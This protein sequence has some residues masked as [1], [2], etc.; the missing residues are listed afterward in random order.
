MWFWVSTIDGI[1]QQFWEDE[2]LYIPGLTR[3]G[4][5]AYSP[6]A[7]HRETIGLS[8]ALEV[9]GAKFFGNGASI[10]GYLKHPGN[11]S[12]EAA[13]RLK[14][15]FE[16]KHRG[17]DT[18]HRIAVLEEGMEFTATQVKPEEAQFVLTRQFQRSDLAGLWRVPPHK[19]G[20][21]SRSTNNNIEHQ[22][23]EFLRDCIGPWMAC[24]EQAANRSLLLPREKGRFF[25]EF[26]INGMLRGDTAA[27][28]AYCNGMFQTG[29]FSPNDILEYNGLNPVEGGDKRFVPLNMV[30]LDQVADTAND[31]D[32]NDDED[33]P[34]PSV[35][36]RARTIQ[37][38]KDVNLRFFQDAMG[39]T[40]HRKPQQRVEYGKNA[41]VQPVL[42]VIQCLLGEISPQMQ[43]FAV[44]FSAEIA[45]KTPILGT[46]E[47][48]IWASR[49]LDRCIDEVVAA[50]SPQALI[51]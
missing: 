33:A 50:P 43:A 42:N 8:K 9:F 5:N 22:D 41:F 48:E 6:I 35:G 37:R 49:S 16:A 23:L 17:L 18:A 20:D 3:E 28:M 4:Y 26:D 11:L 40:M 25:I 13:E 10:G 47:A 45:D 39:R 12:K 32:L 2:I 34:V 51:N 30:P 31:S 36:A 15:S 1:P 21:L 44:S 38:A 7:L 27:R 19:I 46:A 29:A 24:I 14:E